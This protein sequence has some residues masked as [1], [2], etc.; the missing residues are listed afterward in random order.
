MKIEGIGG[1]F[2]EYDLANSKG[3][4]KKIVK[5]SIGESGISGKAFLQCPKK[6]FSETDMENYYNGRFSDCFLSADF[7]NSMFIVKKEVRMIDRINTISLS[8][9][10]YGYGVIIGEK[11]NICTLTREQFDLLKRK[12]KQK[13]I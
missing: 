12:I 6:R 3:I 10:D 7:V 1:F 11:D 9:G 5:N 13:E 2:T 4:T 8:G